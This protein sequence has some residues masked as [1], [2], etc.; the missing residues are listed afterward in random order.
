MGRSHQKT[1]F[2]KV[3]LF[4]SEKPVDARKQWVYGFLCVN[5]SKFGIV[6]IGTKL[7]YVLK[8]TAYFW[9]TDFAV[10][11]YFEKIESPFCII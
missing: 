1:T 3:V 10:F 6:L 11:A 8:K 7:A 4:C 2:F 5:L 9:H